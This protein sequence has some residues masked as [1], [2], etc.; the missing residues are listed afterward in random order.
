MKTTTQT[1]NPYRSVERFWTRFSKNPTQ[2]QSIVTK[3]T[4]CHREHREKAHAKA[5]P[6]HSKTAR[7]CD[8]RKNRRTVG[9]RARRVVCARARPTLKKLKMVVEAMA[10]GG[11]ASPTAMTGAGREREWGCERPIASVYDARTRHGFKIKPRNKSTELM[12]SVYCVWCG[13]VYFGRSI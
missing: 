10:R 7:T 1:H 9:G 3:T 13:W 6:R 12:C 8:I 11:V 4:Q 5:Q 2:N